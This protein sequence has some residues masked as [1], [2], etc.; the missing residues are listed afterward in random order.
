MRQDPFSKSIHFDYT[1]GYIHPALLATDEVSYDPEYLNAAETLAE[2]N[3]FRPTSTVSGWGWTNAT[4]RMKLALAGRAGNFHVTFRRTRC[5]CGV[6]LESKY[7]VDDISYL[8]NGKYD[9]ALSFGH[10]D[11]DSGEIVKVFVVVESVQ[12]SFAFLPQLI[13][14]RWV[15]IDCGELGAAHPEEGLSFKPIEHNC[16][17]PKEHVQPA[18]FPQR[19]KSDT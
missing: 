15:C 9:I 8:T 7:R 12:Q 19:K 3:S 13:N 1:D 16:P 5:S 10:I 17:N 2:W 18:D 14:P 6:R 11:H 4:Q